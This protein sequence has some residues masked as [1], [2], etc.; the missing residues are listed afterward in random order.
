[1]KNHF[2]FGIGRCGTNGL[3][4][5]ISIQNPKCKLLNN[6]FLHVWKTD[7]AN[8]D[9]NVHLK[10]DFEN[11]IP[12]KLDALKRYNNP[13]GFVLTATASTIDNHIFHFL[14]PVCDI[15]LIER[16]WLDC[17]LSHA[18]QIM[19][20]HAE[21]RDDWKWHGP[22]IDIPN[23]SLTVSQDI[24]D[25]F[26]KRYETYIKFKKQMTFK[27]V[28]KFENYTFQNEDFKSEYNLPKKIDYIHNK[29]EVMQFLANLLKN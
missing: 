28:F 15:Y 17:F 8:N 4:T 16:D 14:N 26:T 20:Q 21:G 23:N 6:Y 22:T 5:D 11:N 3:T 19:V 13:N 1:M 7:E 10:V 12:E 27:K 9:L 18:I 2:I 29:Q 24:F 25:M